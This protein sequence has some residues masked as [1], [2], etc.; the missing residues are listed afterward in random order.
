MA[1]RLDGKTG[2]SCAFSALVLGTA[3]TMVSPVVSAQEETPQSQPPMVDDDSGIQWTLSGFVRLETAIHM[4]SD[5]N[6][7]NQ[8]G[9]LFNGK[10]VQ[11]DSNPAPGVGEDVVIRDG[12]KGENDFNLTQMRGQ[13][14]IDGAISKKLRLFARVRAVYDFARYDE[15]DPDSIH[16][17]AVG[18][19]N[20]EVEYFQNR[21]FYHGGAT[22]PL[23][24]A[25]RKYMIDMPS[26]YL[27]YTMGPVLVRFGQQQIAWGQALFFRVLDLPNG[28]DL[29]R[30]LFLDYAPEEYADERIGSLG[31]R[32]TWQVDP[33]WEADAFVQRFLPTLYPNPN[34][35]YNAIASQFTVRDQWNNSYNDKFNGGLRL[36]GNFGAWSTQFTVVRRYNPDGVFKWTKSKVNRD[37]AAIPGSG[38]TLQD[39]AF[40]VDRSGVQSA[41]E[42]FTYAGNAR[43]DGLEGLNA[44]INEFAAA[45]AL[46]AV[47]VTTKDAAGNE[48]DLFFQLSGGLRGHIAREYKRETN[49]GAGVG[50]VV[51]AAPGS[52]LDQLIINLE[53]SFT[54]DRNFTNT[55]LSRD[56]IE[57]DEWIGALVMEKY[58]RFSE[59][60]PATYLVFQWMHRTESDLFG[61]NLKG[62]GGSVNRIAD[63]VDGGWDGL[64]FAMQQPSPTLTWRFDGALLYDTR[65]GILVQ[66][67]LRY[68]PSTSW[69]VEVFYNFIN[70]NLHGGDNKNIMQT[71]EYADELGIRVG[72]Q[73]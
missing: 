41:R 15:Y 33:Q 35:P 67:A 50:Y 37:I 26:L 30:H 70:G 12:E 52:L 42:W 57:D 38:T 9:N 49:I 27:D 3:A 14:D 24:V 5:E 59:S 61:R 22:N 13:W 51:S 31:L 36:R 21:D 71:L 25:G 45:G 8:R 34:T 53:V 69:N 11:R 19:G 65:G 62:M 17:Q 58:Q 63:G 46:G 72:Y 2:W 48:L 20:Q 23:E 66:P 1:I 28:L 47:P 39:T 4:T 68:A 10:P 64:V 16:S 55:T 44:S 18:R 54:P 43:L 60:F 29:R 40:E 32:T 56:Y 7:V 73:F 6:I